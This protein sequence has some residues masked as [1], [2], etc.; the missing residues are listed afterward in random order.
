[1]HLLQSARVPYTNYGTGGAFEL[2]TQSRTLNIIQPEVLYT[3]ICVWAY[4]DN[5]LEHQEIALKL[6]DLIDK[7]KHFESN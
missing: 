4:Q 7:Q 5:C 2:P 3:C 1:M 6:Y